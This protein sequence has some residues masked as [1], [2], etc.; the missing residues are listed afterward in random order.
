[1]QSYPGRAEDDLFQ[2]LLLDFSAAA[3]KS[4]SSAE[5]LKLFCR[6]TRNYFQVSAAYVWQFLPPDQ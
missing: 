2:N 4:N 6:A 3:S 1:V 5:I